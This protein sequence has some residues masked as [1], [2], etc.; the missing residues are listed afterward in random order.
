MASERRFNQ[1]KK[2]LEKKGYKLTRISSSHHIFTKKGSSLISI[3]V[4]GGKV[5]AFYVRQ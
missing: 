1:V 4:H 3:P 5:K 2:R